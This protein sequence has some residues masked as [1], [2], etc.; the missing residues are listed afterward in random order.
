MGRLLYRTIENKLRKQIEVCDFLQSIL[1][2]RS[3]AG[4]A[5]SGLT[6]MIFEI[7]EDYSKTIRFELAIH[8]SPH[9]DSCVVGPYNSILGE[10]FCMEECDVGLLLDNEA[11]FDISC[12][13]LGITKS[14]MTSIN[15]ILGQVNSCITASSRYHSDIINDINAVLTNLV[16]YPR[17]HFPLA[18]FAPLGNSSQLERDVNSVSQIT[19]SVF[20]LNHQLV[21]CDPFNGKYMACSLVYRGLVNTSEIYATLSSIKSSR[22]HRFVDWCPTGFKVGIIDQ[23]PLIL[24]QSMMGETKCSVVMMTN[25]SAVSAV[26]QRLAQKFHRL[27][28]KRSFVHWFVSEG[29]EESEFCE[30]LFNLATLAKDYEEVSIDTQLLQ[31]GFGDGTQKDGGEGE[32]G[33]PTV[34]INA[35]E[36]GT[37]VKD[38]TGEGAEDGSNTSNLNYRSKNQSMNNKELS[39]QLIMSV[40]NIFSNGTRKPTDKSEFQDLNSSLLSW[41]SDNFIRSCKSFLPNSYDLNRATENSETS[42]QCLPVD[43]IGS[44]TSRDNWNANNCLSKEESISKYEKNDSDNEE[45][46]PSILINLISMTLM[47]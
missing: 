35:A 7:L 37:S 34:V 5:G 3:L 28:A 41:D 45:L 24:P 18:S 10:H 31:G 16:P 17:I 20:E 42:I 12:D 26:W 33:N 15:R 8:P 23:P 36:Y 27:Y 13:V 14:T 44:D 47:N 9:F 43:A 29:L 2:H 22:M 19:K 4:G 25:S 32:A 21:K 11:L 30:A 38:E 39:D 6:S 46:E 40:E 1:F